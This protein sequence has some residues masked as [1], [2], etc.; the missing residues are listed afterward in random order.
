MTHRIQLLYQNQPLD[1]LYVIVKT[2]DGDYVTCEQHLY[3]DEEGFL[4]LP[5]CNYIQIC[6]D[7]RC[8]FLDFD[9][10]QISEVMN[11]EFDQERYSLLMH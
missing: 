11:L 3:T 8:I 1:S 10:F 7:D 5:H 4:M 6:M 2:W 9:C